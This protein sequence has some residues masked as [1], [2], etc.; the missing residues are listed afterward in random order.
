MVK[1]AGQRKGHNVFG[2]IESCTGR[3]WYQGQEG[4]LNSDTYIA[5]LTRVLA[6]TTQPILLMPDGARYHP[7]AA[8]P[9]FVGTHIERLTVFQWPSSS[10]DDHPLEKRWKKVNT[11]GTPRHYCPTFDALTDTV[12]P[13]LLKVAH[14]P[15]EIL[16]L[17]RL[18][19]A[20]APA[21]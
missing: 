18:P 21:A 9:R 3:F 5:V 2:L 20:L 8:R 1:T 6:Q 4:R 11:A 7:S 14:T 17:C 12:E 13:A 15:A 19:T 10:P 16:A